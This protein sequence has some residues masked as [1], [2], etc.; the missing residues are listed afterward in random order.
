MWFSTILLPLILLSSLVFHRAQC[1]DPCRLFCTLF[2]HHFF[3]DYTRLQKPTPPNDVQIL[4]RD[5]QSCADDIKAWMCNNELKLNEDKSEAILFS[6]P[7]PSCHCLPSSIMVGTHETVFSDKVGNLGFI[8]DSSFTM[9]QRVIKI[10]QTA[11]CE[12][13][14]I[15]SIRGYLTGR[16]NKRTGDFLCIVQIRL[17]QFSSHGHS[18]LCY[19]ADAESPKYFCTP[20]SQNI[21]PSKLHTFPTGT[22]LVPNF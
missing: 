12:L 7:L 14:R 9:K 18:R 5:L 19:S 13:K 20:Y 22:P 10:C 2:H 1:C 6:T 11:Y 21:T 17:Y 15:S 4:T 16:C 3:A 8:F